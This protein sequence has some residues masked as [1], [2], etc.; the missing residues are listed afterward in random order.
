MKTKTVIEKDHARDQAAAQL[1]SIT[2]MVKNLKS[3]DASQN[4]RQVETYE[5]A[6]TAIQEDALS[7]EVRTGW[8][9]PGEAMD[10]ETAEFN[11]L[12]CT[13]GPAVRI[14]GTLAAADPDTARLEYQDWGT[15]WTEYR[16]TSD[17]EETV[18]RYCRCFYFGE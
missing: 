9:A 15:P 8:Y 13:G 1:E 11:I 12:L 14:I 5:K 18:L 7:I 4:G 16:L 6:E 2:E 3:A 10:A 17:E